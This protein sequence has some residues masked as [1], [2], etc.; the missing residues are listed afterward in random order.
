MP[1]NPIPGT[2]CAKLAEWV[3]FFVPGH[4]ALGTYTRLNT[5]VRTYK[6]VGLEFWPRKSRTVLFHRARRIATRWGSIR[7]PFA[8]RRVAPACLLRRA[9]EIDAGQLRERRGFGRLREINRAVRK[10]RV[11][12][13]SLTIDLH[14][15]FEIFQAAVSAGRGPS[16]RV[17]H[18]IVYPARTAPGADSE[19]VGRLSS[20]AMSTAYL[21]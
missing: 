1:G 2:S 18:R 4:L 11:G 19:L 17:L 8:R 16:L 6:A 21:I 3:N 12:A 14:A 13:T 10:N 9:D 7:N 20:P 5:P 15:V